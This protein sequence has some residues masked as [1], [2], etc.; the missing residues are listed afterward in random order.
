MKNL[1]KLLVVIDYQNDFVSGT[2]R[3]DLAIKIE[4]GIKNVVE[5]TLQSG[6]RVM[7][8]KD[9]HEKDYLQTR[10]GKFLPI[11]H[12][13]KNTNGHNLYGALSEYE[14]CQNENICFLEKFTFGCADICEKVIEFCGGEPDEIEICGVVTDICVI[15]NAILLHSGLLNT[16][17]TI[18]GE[19]CAATTLQGHDNALNVLKGMGYFVTKGE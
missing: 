8:T 7:F 4:S 18:R 12:C 1:K 3:N 17:I 16:K 11:E 10:E 13:I 5:Q 14:Q 19:L 9:T 2:L 15:S 6:G